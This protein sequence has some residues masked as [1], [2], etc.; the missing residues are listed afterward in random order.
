MRSTSSQENT[1]K[2]HPFGRL[3][4]GFIFTSGQASYFRLPSRTRRR[5]DELLAPDGAAVGFAM[6]FFNGR[7]S[8]FFCP[9]YGHVDVVVAAITGE[10][11]E[12]SIADKS[13]LRGTARGDAPHVTLRRCFRSGICQPT[14]TSNI[15]ETFGP[16]R[17]PL[18]RPCL[19]VPVLLQRCSKRCGGA[20]RPPVLVWRW[21]CQSRFSFGR[22]L[23]GLRQVPFLCAHVG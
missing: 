15:A 12:R 7:P 10:I 20:L 5:L 14:P 13:K 19:P 1:K 16:L 6:L 17:V 2:S 18:D 4:L 23:T 22:R 11:A 21:A 3:A 9:G 8:A